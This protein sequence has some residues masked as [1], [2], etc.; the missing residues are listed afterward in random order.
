MTAMQPLPYSTQKLAHHPVALQALRERRHQAPTQIH[1]M[2][3]LACNQ[4]CTFCSYGH[5]LPSDGDEQRGWKNMA[6]M[7]NAFMPL[8]KMA[9][10]V[11]DW[12][13]MGV[14]AIELTG[15][16][17]PLIYPFADEFLR[18]VASWGVDFAL[19]TNG[20]ALTDDRAMLFDE[21][22]WQW[23]RVSID[24]GSQESYMNTRRVLAS[25]W[26]KAWHAVA[27]LAGGKSQPHQRVGVGF[28][29]DRGNFAGVYDA[30]RLAR[31]SGA[32][33]VRVGVA[34]T[35]QNL[36]RFP[37]GALEEAGAQARR[38]AADFSGLQVVDLVSE[39][40]SN[41]LAPAQDYDFC[42]AKEILCVVGGD[43]RVYNCCTL[44][45]N[46]AGLVGS[47]E[48]Q[49]FRA[50]WESDATRAMFAAHDARE[51]CKVPCLYERRNKRALELIT[52]SPTEVAAV[53]AADAG[54][55]RNFI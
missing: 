19:V 51:V 2:P 14:K 31:D 28:V 9:E 10:C 36:A 45:F 23:A 49:S 7:S 33:N 4:S 43:Q 35:P 24:A 8:E 29:V 44:A 48:S 26:H 13:E 15:G 30:C 5:R 50:L 42:A 25:H 20:T 46:P 32:D 12:R 37:E 40:A 34:F 16:G 6:L 1:F 17:E 54:I 38:A 18:L 41:M 47:I 22:N 27:R 55:H 39:R 53:A 21:T 52:M 3:A 11:A